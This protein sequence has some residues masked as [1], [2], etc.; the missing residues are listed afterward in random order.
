MAL[1]V[2]ENLRKSFRVA[3]R[4]PGVRAASGSLFARQYRILRAIDGVS[5]SLEAGELCGYIGPNGAGKSTTIKVLAG[6]LVPDA[7][8]HVE[9]DGRVPW[10]ARAAHVAQLGVVFGQRSQLWWD[11]P[12][13]QSFSLLR[14]IYRVPQD[15][16]ERSLAELVALLELGELSNLP[17]RQLSLGQRMRCD[18]AAALLHEPK[19]LRMRQA[20]ERLRGLTVCCANRVRS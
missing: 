1:I 2:V 20:F 3:T 7:G 18:L 17:A 11:L 8:S 14:S 19:L 16:Y 4:E 9:V 6:I 12:V 15:R 5:F 13:R 10:K